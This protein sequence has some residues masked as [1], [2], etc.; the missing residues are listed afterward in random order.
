[1]FHLL[2]TNIWGFPSGAVVK[3]PPANAKDAKDESSIPGLERSPGVRSSNL[4]QYSWPGK[5]HEQRNLKGCSSWGQEDMSEQLSRH[6]HITN[7]Y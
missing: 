1:M 5:V 2:L 7:I 3:N 6:T 4:L